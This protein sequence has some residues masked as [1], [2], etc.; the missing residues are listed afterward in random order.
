MSRRKPGRL[1]LN[2]FPHAVYVYDIGGGDL[3]AKPLRESR[4]PLIGF[5]GGSDA[6][7][8][9]A[10]LAQRRGF[11][12]AFRM[13]VPRRHR[14]HVMAL[15]G[16]GA[17][18]PRDCHGRPA[19]NLIHAGDNMEN[20]QA[21]RL[22]VDREDSCFSSFCANALGPIT[23]HGST[24]RGVRLDALGDFRPPGGKHSY[25][26]PSGRRAAGA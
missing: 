14:V 10:A 22:A 8:P 5:V 11:L 1:P 26:I 23:L 24:R 12:P 20:P 4:A 15:S 13:P 7:H 21:V 17:R 25:S 6:N 16:L 3:G 9:H 18:E 19:M 2:F